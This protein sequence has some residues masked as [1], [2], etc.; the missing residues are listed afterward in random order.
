MKCGHEWLETR[1]G[2]CLCPECGTQIEIKDTRERVI[3]DKSY[4]NVITTM[5]G[6][7]VVRMFLMIVEMRKGM[8]ANPAYLEIGSYWIDSKGKTS[9]VGLQRTLGHYIDCFAFGSPL[10]IRRD[11]D[12][13]QRISD[14]WVYPRIKVTNT[15]K[16]NGFKGCCHAMHPVTLFQQL[17]TNPKAETLMKSGDVEMLRYL[18]LHPQEVDKYWNSIKVANRNGYNTDSQMWMDYI[19]ML[20]RCG[21]DIQSPKYICPA[22]LKEEHDRYM[23]KVHILEDK[24]K[25][26]EDIRKAQEREASFKEQKE[27]FFGIRINDGEIEVKVLESVEEYRQE[28]ESQ[29]ICLFSAAYDQR[30]DSLIFSAR[31]DG[32]I[33]ETIEVDLRT[34]R[35]VQSRGVCNKNTAYHDRIINLINANTHLIKERITA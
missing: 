3:R 32:R 21:K 18:C 11:N 14:E 13:F 30:E 29:H 4:F 16:R 20:E 35:V 24:K 34:L 28:A 33:I 26:A 1:N 17:L 5:E 19:K 9:V 6:Y 22:N 25:R 12:A 31:I 2:M 15:I 10:E 23:R 8:K 7:Q 27:K